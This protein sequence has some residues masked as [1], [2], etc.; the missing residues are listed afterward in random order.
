MV[1]FPIWPLLLA[2][3]IIN[4]RR[5]QYEER[6][7]ASPL[8]YDNW[9]DYLRLEESTGDIDRTREVSGS[10]GIIIDVSRAGTFHFVSIASHHTSTPDSARVGN[11]K[12]HMRCIKHI[13]CLEMFGEDRVIIHAQN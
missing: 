10:N 13:R 12:A 3:V 5:L 1:L 4:N 11:T 8:D 7:S 9:F 2:K 6:A